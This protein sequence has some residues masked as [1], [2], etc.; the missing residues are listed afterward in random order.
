MECYVDGISHGGEG[1]ARIEGKAT[2]IPYTIP[3]ETVDAEIAEEK[4]NYQ[5][6]RV[7][8]IVSPSPDRVKPPCRH[9][10]NCG[11]CSYQHV[12]YPRQLELKQ[13]TVTDA[14][15]RIGGID[16][17]VNPVIGMD[18]PWHYRNKVEW[19]AGI[20][21]GRAVLGY[22]INNSHDLIPIDDCPLISEKMQSCSRYI[23]DHYRELNL[24]D[25]GAVTV[26]QSSLG[27]L[28]LIFHGTGASKI[29]FPQL[30]DRI[31]VDSV[32]SLERGKLRHHYGSK[33]LAEQLSGLDFEI[34]PLSFFQVNHQQ[35]EK[36]LQLIK[37]YAGL[38]GSENLLDAF[39]GTGSMALQLAGSIKTVT[40]VESLTAAV[41]DAEKNAVIN[42]ISNCRFISG[43]CEQII[44]ALKEKFD[45]VV[46]DPPRSGCKKA[47]IQS[48]I[49]ISPRTIIYVSCNPATLA[50]DLALF[51]NTA[52]TIET[53][54]PLDM[55]SQTGHVENIILLQRM[56]T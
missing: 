7:K 20:V 33:S 35:T 39:C 2:F 18:N 36:M 27:Q 32:F 26:R 42:H 30:T 28:M 10:Y 56:S 51:N 53:V 14:L 22:Y 13:Q 41:Q 17:K 34:S 45:V 4:P 43:K 6:G 47:L 9:F 24:P 23:A 8:A 21:A 19:H 50:R 46:L 3:G 52:Y 11:G 31:E 40:G 16:I 29:D 12:A 48:V 54:Q 38:R 15:Y 25:Q 44:P 49:N 37:A 5:R 1:V 55:F